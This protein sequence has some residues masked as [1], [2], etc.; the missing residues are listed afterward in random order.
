MII[1][2][3]REVKG[4]EP[5]P[6]VL[7]RVVAG[8]DEGAPHFAMRVFEIQPGSSTPYHTHSWEHEVF[9]LSGL[10]A[11]KTENGETGLGE[12][13]AIFVPPDE[14]HCFINTGNELLR[15]ICVVPLFDGKMPG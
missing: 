15:F 8:P 13:K 9:I 12:G 14:K 11:V 10:G 1:H 4:N 7:M 6:G 2:D 5:V 3:H